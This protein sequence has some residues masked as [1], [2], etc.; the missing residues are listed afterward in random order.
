MS[1][2]LM[3]M[4]FYGILYSVLIIFI[5]SSLSYKSLMRTH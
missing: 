5:L 2:E 4:A 3:D 1:N